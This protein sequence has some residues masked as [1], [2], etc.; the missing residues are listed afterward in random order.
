ML[1]QIGQQLKQRLLFINHLITNIGAIEARDIGGGVL[2]SQPRQ[3]IGPGLRI[4]GG[5]Q[6]NQRGIGKIAPQLSQ[7]DIFGTKI[8]APLRNAVSFVNRKQGDRKLFQPGKKTFAHQALGS[9]VQK[10]QF[11]PMQ[12]GKYLPTFRSPQR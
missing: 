9:D 4:G 5:C 10:I 1:F 3:D 12:I 7:R 6:G 11:T 2:Q 8:M